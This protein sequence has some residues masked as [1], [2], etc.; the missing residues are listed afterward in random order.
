MVYN[1]FLQQRLE[2]V[3]LEILNSVFTRIDAT[4]NPNYVQLIQQIY[5]VKV[6]PLDFENAKAAADHI[7]QIISDAT[8]GRL[9]QIVDA[10]MYIPLCTYV[11]I[12][13]KF[14]NL[15]LP[16]LICFEILTRQ[17]SIIIII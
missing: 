8:K 16:Y 10:G 13:I 11:T 5:G 17:L 1:F 2:G 9:T 4:L 15:N 14:G 7:N 12:I 6:K 3:T